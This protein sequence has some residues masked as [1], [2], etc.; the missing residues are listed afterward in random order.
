MAICTII[1]VPRTTSIYIVAGKLKI[2]DLD[3]FIRLK[4]EPMVVPK[5]NDNND[6]NSVTLIPVI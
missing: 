2:F 6:N 1:G 5:T 4:N 3:S